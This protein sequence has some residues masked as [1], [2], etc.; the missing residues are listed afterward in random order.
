M[1]TQTNSTVQAPKAATVAKP[2]FVLAPISPDTAVQVGKGLVKAASKYE[3]AGRSLLAEVS[4]AVRLMGAT[5]LTAAQWVKQVQ[6]CIRDAFKRSKG[7]AETTAASYLS[8]FKTAGLAMLSG[9]ASLQPLAG[10]SLAVYCSR[11]AEPLA[12][13]VLADGRPVFDPDVV[14][15]GRPPKPSKA[16]GN[17]S[18]GEADRSEGG[19]NRTPQLAAALILTG[20]NYVLAQ[21]LTVVMQSYKDD[22]AKWTDGIL[23]ERDK[24]ELQAKVQPKAA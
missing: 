20:D 22:F 10:E 18:K 5:P 9:D 13:H 11:V 23:T 4:G 7:I 14:R 16:T 1:T 17:T 8:R 12:K 24:K 15:T 2:A 19:L 6:P 21:R 3:G